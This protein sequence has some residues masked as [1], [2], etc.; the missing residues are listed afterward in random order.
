[1]RLTASWIFYILTALLFLAA[2]L[3]VLPVYAAEKT[4]SGVVADLNRIDPLQNP[5]Y[6]EGNDLL[7]RHIL[8]RKNKVVGEVEDVVVNKNGNI[9]YLNV[10]FDRL[11]RSQPVFVNYFEYNV[12]PVTNGYALAF[13]SREVD[14]FYPALLAGIEAAAGDDEAFSLR[15]L[16]GLDVVTASGRRIG[17]VGDVLFAYN[18]QRA[19]ALYI[20]LDVDTLRGKGVAV[21][22]SDASYV[23]AA[24]SRQ[25]SIPDNLADAAIAFA[26]AN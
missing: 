15:K 21:P 4:Q 8:D 12:K 23:E 26:R 6:D 5:R 7:K 9:A 1:M 24:A 2:C 20:R 14:E 16:Q 3:A 25:I 13:D 17:T 22:F 18:G 10:Q 11:Q 19:E